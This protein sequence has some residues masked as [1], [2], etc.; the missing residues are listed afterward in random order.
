MILL[1]LRTDSHSGVFSAVTPVN[2]AASPMTWANFQTYRTS[3]LKTDLDPDS[4]GGILSPDFLNYVDQTQAY[5]GASYSIWE[6]MRDGSPERYQVGNEIN[7]TT[8]MASG[9]GMF[10]GLWRFLYVMLW[11]SGAELVFDKY[12]LADSNETVV[13]ANLLCDVGCTFPSAFAAIYQN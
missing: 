4:F 3:I 10:L 11:G 13:R 1:S 12:T 9:K 8:G 5:T 7:S 2:L 6:K